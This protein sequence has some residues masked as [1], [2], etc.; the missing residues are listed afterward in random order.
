MADS[1]GQLRERLLELREK[2]TTAT[3]AHTKPKVAFVFCGQGPQWWAMGRELYERDPIVREMW[4]RCDAACKKAGGPDLLKTLLASE[5]DSP[6]ARTDFTQPALF[7]LQAGLVERWRAWGIEADAVLGHSV[8]EAAAA[9]AA[10]I[11]DLDEIFRVIMARSGWQAKTHGLG[12]MLAAGMS[13]DEAEPWIKQFAG[14]I[15]LAA[16]NAPNQ[17]TLSGEAGPLE[18]IAAALQ[19]EGK[20]CRLLATPYAFH[21]AQMDVI[22]KGMREALVGTVGAPA[23]LPM[24]STMTGRPVRGPELDA[25]YWW[26]NVR[27]PVRFGAGIE[28]LLRDGCTAFIEIGPHPVMASAI[29]EIAQIGKKPAISVASLRREEGE[30]ATMLQALG[31]LYRH[32]APVRWEALY[33]RPSRAIRLPAYPWQRQRLWHESADVDRLLRSAPPHPLLGDRQ[34]HPQ[35]TWMNRLD[36]RVVPW[37]ADHRLAGSAVLPAA[38]YVEMAAAAVREFL[39]SR[40][41]LLEDI[42]FHRM[43]FLPEEHPVPT[44]VRLDPAA[45]RFEVLAA[46]PE[47]P[48][49]WELYAEGVFRNGR[50][51]A[52]AASMSRRCRPASRKSVPRQTCMTS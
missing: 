20:F 5:A 32:G 40:T 29:A 19:A 17:I 48:S 50:L 28:R 14:R 47:T 10:G 42:R 35:P 2:T 25:D 23:R 9:W 43:L 38:A 4:E 3:P 30:S 33:A 44:C 27:Q 36:A 24:I 41:V 12:R 45:G 52:P 6:L 26:R 16:L 13:A 51:R 21:S 49:A 11:F 1:L 39:G 8:G 7:A 46:P 15:S 31:T 34:Q 37:L 22:E 18:E